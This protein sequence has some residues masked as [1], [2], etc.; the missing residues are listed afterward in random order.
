[1]RREKKDK[2]GSPTTNHPTTA[3]YDAPRGRGLDGAFN[4]IT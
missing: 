3:I 4:D 2:K 1:L